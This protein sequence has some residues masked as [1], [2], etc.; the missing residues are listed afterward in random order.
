MI[1]YKLCIVL[2]LLIMP[3]AIQAQRKKGAVKK[4]K[5]EEPTEDPR[6]TQMLSSVQQIMFIDSVVVDQGNFMSH[7]P[8]SSHIGKLT[9]TAGLGTF[10]SEMGDHRLCTTTDTTIAETDFI[11]NR[12]TEARAVSGIGS[13]PAI[14]PFLMPDGITLYYAQKG[15]KSIGGFDIFVTRYDS[16]KRTFLKPENIGMP[17]S[18]EADDLFYAIDEFNQL[19]YFVTNR[20]QPAN[21]V[22]I[23]TFIPQES[24][25]SYHSEAYTEQQLR[26]LAAINRIADTWEKGQTR[27]DA[28]ARLEEARAAIGNLRNKDFKPQDQTELDALRHEADVL[29]KTLALTRK[30]YAT[31]SDKERTV[32]RTKILDT[33]QQLEQLQM[34]IKNKEK[35][36]PYHY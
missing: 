8:L 32:L 17:F 3:L 31:A 20:R 19:G 34:D 16:E 25:R 22:C 10:T 6:I 27:K 2:A 33:E 4:A 26:S 21:K 13:S 18:S 36:I 35:Q 29:D 12:W 14:N 9:Q 30:H 24:R 15:E 7:I 5:V 11:A 28:L 1:R 23:Y